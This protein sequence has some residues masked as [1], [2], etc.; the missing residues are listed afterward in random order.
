MDYKIDLHVHTIASQH[1]YSTIQEIAEQAKIK[2]LKAFAITDHGPAAPDGPY[3]YYFSNLRVLPDYINGVRVYRGVEANIISE[4][5]NLDLEKSDLK[6]M[7][8]ILAGFHKLTGYGDSEVGRNTKA[9]INAIKNGYI[10]VIAHMEH[11]LFPVD[12]EKVI[13]TAKEYNTAIELNNSSFTGSREGGQK[14]FK[15]IMNFAKKYGVYISLGSDSHVSFSVG[16]LSKSIQLLKEYEYDES[17]VI[18]QS[19]DFFENF[20]KNRRGKN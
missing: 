16:E 9:L 6:K 11:P 12:Y 17:L 1:A 4:N 20:I 19:M 10:D 18:N 8:I 3:R 7:E 15:E 5:G 2:E 13:K 14:N